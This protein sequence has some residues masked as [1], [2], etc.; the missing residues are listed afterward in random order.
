MINSFEKNSMRYTEYK[1]FCREIE[2]SSHLAKMNEPKSTTDF[3]NE[4]TDFGNQQSFQ[5]LKMF[6]DLTLVM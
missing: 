4:K 6:R 1:S 3:R 5:N 2:F